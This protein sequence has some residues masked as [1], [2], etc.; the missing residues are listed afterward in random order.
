MLGLSPSSVQNVEELGK[1]LEQKRLY[2]G[3][4]PCLIWHSDRVVCTPLKSRSEPVEGKHFLFLFHQTR[5]FN[6]ALNRLQI[7]YRGLEWWP[8]SKLVFYAGLCGF[9]QTASPHTLHTTN[10]SWIICNRSMNVINWNL[11]AAQMEVMHALCKSVITVDRC[12]IILLLCSSL[13]ALVYGVR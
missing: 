4:L 8:S 11:P 7:L 10:N 1:A 13:Y 9:I 5:R 3:T 6:F 12:W 2:H